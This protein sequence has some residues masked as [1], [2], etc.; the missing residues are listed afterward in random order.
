MKIPKELMDHF[1]VK[2]TEIVFTNPKRAIIKFQDDWIKDD[3][4]EDVLSINVLEGP[5]GATI[6]V[7]YK[8]EKGDGS[9][10]SAVKNINEIIIVD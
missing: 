4:R 8:T 2:V 7:H 5:L 3:V 1:G 6:D 10:G 9:V